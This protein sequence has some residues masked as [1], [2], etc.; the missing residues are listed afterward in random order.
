MLSK[1][2][3]KVNWRIV[4]FLIVK[5]S[6]LSDISRGTKTTKAN[7]FYALKEL[8]ELDFVRKIIRGRTHVYRFNFLHP[9]SKIIMDMY[10]EER[11]K[12]YNK[13]LGNMPIIIHSL[14]SHSLKKSYNGCIFFGSSL[15][16]KYND[17]DI[18]ILM[19]DRQNTS[20]IETKLK[21][22]D[23]NVSPLFGSEKEIHNGIKNQD[24]FYKNILSGI[25]F[26]SDI[27]KIKYEDMFLRKADINERLIIGY[28]DV[29]SCLEFTEKEY[30]KVHLEKGS[31][32]IIY[33]LLNYFDFSPKNGREAISLFKQ[34]FKEPKPTTAKQAIG[35][36]KK[37]AWIL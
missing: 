24:M 36:V 3:K 28:R 12:A 2:I 34:K 14:L 15:E 1:I 11:R 4:T 20:E 26:G 29:L 17:I 7:T 13:K 6:S 16:G 9:Q 19:E 23:K 33:A 37:Y 8:E 30:V 5:E 31:M 25:S 35:L 10:M 22:I 27:G 32:D 21:L 18:F